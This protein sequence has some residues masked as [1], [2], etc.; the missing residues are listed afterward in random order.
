MIRHRLPLCMSKRTGTR[1]AF[2][3][4]EILLV[5]A[6]LS[7]IASMVVPNILARQRA[8]NIDTTRINILAAEQALTMYLIDHPGDVIAPTEATQVL[9]QADPSD[10]RWNGPYVKN[11]PRD[12]W[13]R[14]LLARSTDDPTIPIEFYS[15]GADG[16]A[17]TTDDIY[18]ESHDSL[19]ESST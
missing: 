15:A 18:G 12:A 10:T 9:I 8:A 4:L 5:V 11:A 17:D 7:A 3:L 16:T 1:S 13:G 14:S 6:I 2:T 19:M